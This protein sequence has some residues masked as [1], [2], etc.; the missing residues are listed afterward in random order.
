MIANG[1][2]PIC[3]INGIMDQYVYVNILKN[4][5]LPFA[6][7]KLDR[8]WIFQADN[9]PKHTSNRAK[10]FLQ[11]QK[12]NVL[13]WPSQSPDLNPIEHLW[14]DV[15]KVNKKEKPSNL[16]SLYNIIEDSWIIS[17]SIGV[18]H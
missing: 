14:N 17:R 15:D 4:H 12:I 3:R 16:E 5:L 2:G 7:E 1:P 18:F 9:D 6:E 10:C 8:N 11:R 13:S